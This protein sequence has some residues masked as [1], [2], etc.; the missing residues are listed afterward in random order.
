M[1]QKELE[2]LINIDAK[3]SAL[4]EQAVEKFD[5]SMRGYVKILRLALTIAD[6]EDKEV[7]LN[8]VVQALQFRGQ[9]KGDYE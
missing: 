1:S 7:K 5:L 3:M 9:T 2:K 4:L 6:L 8:H